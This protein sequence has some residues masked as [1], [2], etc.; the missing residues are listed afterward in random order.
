MEMSKTKAER[1]FYKEMYKKRISDE[2]SIHRFNEI[3]CQST[4]STLQRALMESS[5][6]IDAILGTVDDNTT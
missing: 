1:A 5:K 2:A 6:G 3:P 4:G